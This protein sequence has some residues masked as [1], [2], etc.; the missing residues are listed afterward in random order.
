MFPHLQLTQLDQQV[1]DFRGSVE[2]RN[3]ELEN[4]LERTQK[5]LQER[6]IQVRDSSFRFLNIRLI[7]YW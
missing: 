1:R 3:V 2:K 7:F 6:N 5:Q 4:E